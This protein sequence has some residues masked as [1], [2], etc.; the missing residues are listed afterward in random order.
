MH[1]DTPMLLEKEVLRPNSGTTAGH[2]RHR[3]SDPRAETR[4]A[5]PGSR[6]RTILVNM[7]SEADDTGAACVT[8]LAEA[9][10]RV[11]AITADASMPQA[12]SE[13][14]A[15][16]RV[17][18]LPGSA[19]NAASLRSAIKSLPPLF[20]CVDAAVNILHLLASPL[21]L[22]DADPLRAH[23]NPAASLDKLLN[24]TRAA[25]PGLLASERGHVIAVT[26]TTLNE[27][28]LVEEAHAS[29]LCKALRSEL[30]DLGVR[31]TRV[32]AGPMS[33]KDSMKGVP[34]NRPR[35]NGV[36]R[37]VLASADVAQA[38]AWTLAQPDHVA[39]RELLICPAPN[40]QPALSPREREVLEWTACGKTSEEIAC[41]LALSV[42][43]VNFHVRSLLVKLQC[44]NKTAAVARAAL[45]GM[46]I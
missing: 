16:G 37:G 35:S 14:I 43:A 18:T 23:P 45:L 20:R 36:E 4:K 1:K 6:P 46:L 15:N 3:Q 13:A 33:R 42:S 17:A 28:N 2:V 22:L 12:L 8:S 44:C 39:V 34:G 10:H 25:M 31:F 38:I 30:D 27:G 40:G 5:H 26:L 21:S 7:V 29:A 19:M 24:A 32:V 11:I 9:G 41:I